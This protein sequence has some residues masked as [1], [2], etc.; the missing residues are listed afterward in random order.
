MKRLKNIEGKNKKTGQVD[1]FKNIFF[2]NK[3]NSEAKKVYDKIKEQ[4]KN[5]DSTK[6]F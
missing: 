2:R 6:L 4:S 3:L 5:I 1:D